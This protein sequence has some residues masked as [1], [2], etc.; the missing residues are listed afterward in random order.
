MRFYHLKFS[1]ILPDGIKLKDCC[2]T[3]YDDLSVQMNL[4][5]AVANGSQ[6]VKDLMLLP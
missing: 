2:I 5:L 4:L 6:I 1:I 3:M